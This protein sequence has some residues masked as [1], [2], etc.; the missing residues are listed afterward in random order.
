MTTRYDSLV[1][2]YIFID[3]NWRFKYYNYSFEGVN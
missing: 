2:L 1:I 3:L